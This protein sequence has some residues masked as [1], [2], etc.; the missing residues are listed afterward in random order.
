MNGGGIRAD[1]PRGDITINTLLNVMPFNNTVVVAE[2]SGQTMK[3]M[4]EMTVMAWPAEDGSFP[5][6]SGIT[7]SVNTSIPSSVMIN[8]QEEFLEVAGEYRVYDIKV[9][10]REKGTYEPLDLDGT[11][12]IAASNYFLLDCG[13]GMTMFENA[14]ILRDDGILDVE[15]VQWYIVEMLNG[16]VGQQYQD[17][18]PNITFIEGE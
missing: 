4:L 3:D 7:F 6:L 13:S 10:N 11:Y 2:V 16:V 9:Y 12:T 18:M 1:I 15:V 8:E 5:H 17:T 14:R